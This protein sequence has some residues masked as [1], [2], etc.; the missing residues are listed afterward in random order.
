MAMVIQLHR[1][2]IGLGY[3]MSVHS[4]V[5]SPSN[6]RGFGVTFNSL[7]ILAGQW[8]VETFEN[9]PDNGRGARN[10]GILCIGWE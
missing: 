8:N 7:S 1:G 5:T 4:G 3:P 6:V 9:G 2:H 10:L